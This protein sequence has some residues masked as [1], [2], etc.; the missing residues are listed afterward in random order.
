MYK[1]E[2]GRRAYL[3]IDEASELKKQVSR[4]QQTI[5]EKDA[6]IEELRDTIL[7]AMCDLTEADIEDDDGLLETLTSLR[8]AHAKHPRA[9]LADL[10]QAQQLIGAKAM[11]EACANK[12]DDLYLWHN[13]RD[14]EDVQAIYDD[15]VGQAIRNIKAEEV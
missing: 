7:Y 6:Y 9:A 10:K 14:P 4:L 1:S 5:E 3:G 15:D 2:E 8:K 13:E 11:Q 12:A